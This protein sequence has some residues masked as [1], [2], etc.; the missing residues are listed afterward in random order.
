MRSLKTE[1]RQFDTFV[2]TGGTAGCRNN[3]VSRQ[4]RQSCQIDD[5][6]FSM[7]KRTNNNESQ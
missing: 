6:L 3:N 1:G 7:F 5:L 4:W 2:V